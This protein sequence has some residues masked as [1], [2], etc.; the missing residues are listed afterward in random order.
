MNT[1]SGRYLLSLLKH[2]LTGDGSTCLFKNCSALPRHI[3]QGLNEAAENQLT[4]SSCTVPICVPQPLAQSPRFLLGLKCSPEKQQ[5][6]T[7]RWWTE[8]TS[9]QYYFPGIQLCMR[10]CCGLCSSDSLGWMQ[11]P[12]SQQHI[13]GKRNWE[14]LGTVMAA[15]MAVWAL[16]ALHAVVHWT[17]FLQTMQEVEVGHWQAGNRKAK[18]WLTVLSNEHSRRDSFRKKIPYQNQKNP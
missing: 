12:C 7:R 14:S 9:V 11:L 1:E 18:L 6:H 15:A 2:C 17:G 4:I 8:G 3:S 5:D 16:S 13:V 10:S